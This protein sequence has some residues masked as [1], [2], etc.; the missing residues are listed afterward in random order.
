[1]TSANDDIVLRK[2]DEP[3]EKKLPAGIYAV[4]FDGKLVLVRRL[5]SRFMPLSSKE[6]EE[7]CRTISSP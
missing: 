5:A 2:V 6:Q 1:M 7:I 4:V 3:E